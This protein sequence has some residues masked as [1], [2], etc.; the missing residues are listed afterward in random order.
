MLKMK[1]FFGKDS[2]YFGENGEWY[3]LFNYFRDADM[4]D[5]ANLEYI[6]SF[7]DMNHVDIAIE[8]ASHW[9]FGWIEYILINPDNTEFVRAAQSIQDRLK[10]YP[11]FDDEIY[12]RLQWEQYEQCI[13]YIE[14][15]WRYVELFPYIMEKYGD[16]ITNKAFGDNEGYIDIDNI[17]DILDMY[18]DK[19]TEE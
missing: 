15:N 11:L 13:D 7:F 3:V 18:S 19:L 10:D 4:I 1:E 12:S 8:R 6:R 9:A 2:C 14:K 5:M 16:D 17:I